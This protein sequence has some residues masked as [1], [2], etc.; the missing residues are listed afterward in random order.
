MEQRAT[1][2][3][4]SRQQLVESINIAPGTPP[5]KAHGAGQPV[6]ANTGQHLRGAVTCVR[7]GAVFYCVT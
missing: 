5:I 6:L 1:P 7:R 4:R 2:S 3:P